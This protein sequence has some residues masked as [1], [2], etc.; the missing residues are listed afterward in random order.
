VKFLNGQIKNSVIS[1]GVHGLIAQALQGFQ[2]KKAINLFFSCIE[3]N[4]M[5]KLL[6]FGSFFLSFIFAY[7]AGD[8]PSVAGEKVNIL[9]VWC[10]GSSLVFFLI[11]LFL[12]IGSDNKKDDKA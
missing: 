10:A 4:E 1:I 6:I 5:N 12:L 9:Q 11:P 8:M 7:F 3:V 2:I